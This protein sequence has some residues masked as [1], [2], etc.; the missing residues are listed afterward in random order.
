LDQDKE[1][2]RS[3]CG[4]QPRQKLRGAMANKLVQVSVT[5]I[6]LAVTFSGCKKGAGQKKID[7]ALKIMNEKDWCDKHV[8]AA[9]GDGNKPMSPRDFIEKARK[10]FADD[11]D[12]AKKYYGKREDVNKKLKEFTQKWNKQEDDKLPVWTDIEEKKEH[13]KKEIAKHQKV[14]D[15]DKD[16][17]KADKGGDGDQAASDAGGNTNCNGHFK[18]DEED[19]AP[20][21]D[22]S[23]PVSTTDSSEAD[24][25]FKEDEEDEAP[26]GD[27]SPS[28]STTDSSE[29]GA[30]K[31]PSLNVVHLHVGN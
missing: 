16:G 26:S 17:K 12:K 29:A 9:L 2:H 24:G 31:P 22:D 23:P 11:A 27:D 30:P 6:L 8:K 21:G 19:E 15:K 25:H 28:V 20:S 1:R 5:L 10:D 4:A 13:K 7:K 18:E 14:T 3:Y